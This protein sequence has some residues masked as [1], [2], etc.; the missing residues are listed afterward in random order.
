[1]N[2]TAMHPQQ[3]QQQQQQQG[4]L[5]TLVSYNLEGIDFA[6]AG[7]GGPECAASLG[8]GRR[9]AED[10]AGVA[11]SAS[12]LALGLRWHR[13]P[14]DKEALG[15]RVRTNEY[16]PARVALLVAMTFAYALEVTPT[17]GNLDSNRF[18]H[19]TD[20]PSSLATRWPPAR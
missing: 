17:I 20:P 16:A 18:I 19:P 9:L 12:S 13:P 1:M 14:P 4:L 3:Q 10:A 11:L 8:W 6:L 5:A 2:A 7:N 15:R